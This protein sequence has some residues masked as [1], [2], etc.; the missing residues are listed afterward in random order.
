[1][2]VLKELELFIV[3]RI[4]LLHILKNVM[5]NH[6]YS[7]KLHLSDSLIPSSPQN[8]RSYIDANIL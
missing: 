3:H 5:I 1:M 8:H 6:I 2:N 4:I 7:G